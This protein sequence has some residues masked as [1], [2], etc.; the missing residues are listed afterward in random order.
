MNDTVAINIDS[1]SKPAITVTGCTV[2]CTYHFDPYQFKYN[3]TEKPIE[4]RGR[5]MEKF[6]LD[7]FWK[8]IYTNCEEF[9]KLRKY[10]RVSP[11]SFNT[12]ILLLLLGVI[13]LIVGVIPIWGKEK[14][15]KGMVIGAGV[16]VILSLV[17]FLVTK[18]VMKKV[19]KARLFPK[20]EEHITKAVYEHFEEEVGR[21]LHWRA[22]RNGFRCIEFWYSMEDKSVAPHMSVTQNTMFTEGVDLLRHQGD[23]SS[24]ERSSIEMKNFFKDVENQHSVFETVRTTRRE[25]QEQP[26]SVIRIKP[27]DTERDLSGIEAGKNETE[28]SSTFQGDTTSSAIIK[29]VGKEVDIVISKSDSAKKLCGAI[30]NVASASIK[31]KSGYMSQRD[32]DGEK[33]L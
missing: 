5:P 32:E 14:L 19:F 10:S 13:L 27:V 29:P 2:Y 20:Y 4:F 21:G 24:I 18:T 25:L 16:I 33:G 17:Q 23:R 9:K 7:S 8:Q 28:V 11:I 1:P 3:D 31:E 15:N 30:V 6:R 12:G 22:G 26:V